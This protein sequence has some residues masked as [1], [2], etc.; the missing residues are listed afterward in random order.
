[1]YKKEAAQKTN[2]P[3]R[4]LTI[5]PTMPSFKKEERIFIKPN[6]KKPIKTNGNNL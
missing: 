6:I 3:E 4:T 2:A 5:N 1:M